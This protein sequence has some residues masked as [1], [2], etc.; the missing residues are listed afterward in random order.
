[1]SKKIIKIGTRGSK[2]ALTQTGYVIESLSQVQ[3]DIE[4]KTVIIKTAGDSNQI[5]SLEK[6]GGAGLF[7][8]KIESE[9]LEGNIDLAVHSAKDLP[10]VMTESLTIAAVPVREDC[11]DAWLTL[12]GENLDDIKAGARV[13]TGSPR[14]RAQILNTRPDLSVIDMRGNVETRLRKMKEGVCDAL[15]MAA[16][17]LKRIGYENHITEYL[18]PDSFIPAPGQ[19]SLIVQARENDTDIIETAKVINDSGADRCLKIERL[20]LEKL[21]AGCSAAVGGRARIENNV[22]HL[23][24]VVLDK[25]G[26]KRLFKSAQIDAGQPDELLVDMVTED[27]FRRGAGELIE[28]I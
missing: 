11:R 14:R 20:L 19:G 28:Q 5:A 16:A 6:I 1:M 8:R 2:L 23:D 21:N 15:L 18:P 7:T 4:L 9:L 22:I 17:G 3:S 13:G 25:S 26:R 10:S 24:A 27:L 12:T